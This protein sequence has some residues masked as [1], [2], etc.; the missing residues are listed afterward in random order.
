M[1][2][3]I[4]EAY[5]QSLDTPSLFSCATLQIKHVQAIFL[6]DVC[7][8]CIKGV[9]WTRILISQ[10]FSSKSGTIAL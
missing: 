4:A 8:L 9:P 5:E 7:C 10:R 3:V 1:A 2:V 6:K